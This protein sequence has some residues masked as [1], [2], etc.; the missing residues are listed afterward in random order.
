MKKSKLRGKGVSKPTTTRDALA[1]TL[2]ENL[3]KQFK[4][5]KAA[6]F[7]DGSEEVAAST[8]VVDWIS[9]GDDILDLR[10]SNRPNGGIPVGKITEIFGAE[11]SGKSLLLSQMIAETQ[12]RGGVAVL[13]DTESSAQPEFLKAIGVDLSNLLY[14]QLDTVEE[15]FE[16]AT[17]IITNVREKN[18]DRL[19]FIAIDS[20]A[21]A[22]TK[23]EMEQD[24]DKE[25]FATAKALILSKAMRKVTNLIAKQRIAFVVT[26]QIRTKLG[27]MFGDP[28][29]T[30]GGRAVGFHSSVR[31]KL[32]NLGKLEVGKTGAK[33]A[34]GVK[35]KAY[36][37]KNR[38]GPPLRHCTVEMYFN[39]GVDKYAGWINGLKAKGLAEVSSGKA[40]TVTIPSLKLNILTKKF[41]ETMKTDAETREKIYKLICDE[42]IMKYNGEESFEVEDISI[43]N[44][45]EE[46]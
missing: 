11:S 7:L 45:T 18:R 25:G 10:I 9:T 32:S 2:A 39:R 30:P 14:L 46:D 38:V 22:S 41:E 8:N 44:E 6:H 40:P 23:I 19:V 37:K 43:S 17:T 42:Y 27:V 31:I 5:F 3:N 4:E 33:E 16:A 36:I 34:I 1:K 28:D 29:T 21:G 13:I 20:I 24:F 15:A 35:S 12:R 26:N